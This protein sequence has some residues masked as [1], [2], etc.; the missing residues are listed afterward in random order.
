M[1]EPLRLIL[2][3]VFVFLLL[4]CRYIKQIACQLYK[5]PLKTTTYK[6]FCVFCDYFHTCVEIKVLPLLGLSVTWVGFGNS[7]CCG[8]AGNRLWHVYR[9]LSSGRL[10][11]VKRLSG[12]FCYT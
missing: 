3:M 5:N 11:D 9:F 8:Q 4:L 6:F 10:R 7:L 12:Q 2:I 1:L